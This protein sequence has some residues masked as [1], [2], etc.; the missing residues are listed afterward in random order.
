MLDEVLA[1]P[2]EDPRRAHAEVEAIIAQRSH[3]VTLPDV[4]A[5]DSHVLLHGGDD[6][7]VDI[8]KPMQAVHDGQS[9]ALAQRVDV[10]FEP[11]G[12]DHQCLAEGEACGRAQLCQR[13]EYLQHMSD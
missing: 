11:L 2:L 6:G 4:A 8:L 5:S 13:A 10:D 1:S 7:L 12:H 9:L 3:K